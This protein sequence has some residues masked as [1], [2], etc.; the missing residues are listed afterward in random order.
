MPPR[1]VC[2][3]RLNH[4]FYNYHTDKYYQCILGEE[5][6]QTKQPLIVFAPLYGS[7]QYTSMKFH[8]HRLCSCGVRSVGAAAFSCALCAGQ[9]S[10]I[11]EVFVFVL[12][13]LLSF[14][15]VC[16]CV[17]VFTWA[18]FICTC[19]KVNTHIDGKSYITLLL[20]GKSSH[21]LNLWNS[22]TKAVCCYV[23]LTGIM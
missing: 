19:L 5:S 4:C 18:C 12:L 10:F 9:K 13:F 14:S 1:P 22:N 3:H 21:S 6:T 17:C 20:P 16:V 11:Q 8:I 7:Y 23:R 2:K 15:T